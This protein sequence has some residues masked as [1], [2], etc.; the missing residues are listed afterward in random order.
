MA[1]TKKST[2]QRSTK[3]QQKTKQTV[4][5]PVDDVSKAHDETLDGTSQEAHSSHKKQPSKKHLM[6]TSIIS[7]SPARVRRF[8]DKLTLNAKLD[9]LADPLKEQ[10]KK[11]TSAEKMLKEKTTVEKDGKERSATEQ[12]LKKAKKTV[13][14]FKS[15]IPELDE[16]LKAISKERVRFS[17]KASIVLAIICD[18]LVEQ[19]AEH[20]INNVINNNKKIIHVSHLFDEEF[21]RLPL[22]PLVGSLPLL[23]K[24]KKEM[25]DKQKQS[26]FEALIRAELIK[27]EKK[28]KAEYKVHKKKEQPESEQQHEPKQQQEHHHQKSHN[29]HPKSEFSIYVEQKCRKLIKSNTEYSTLRMSTEFKDFLAHLVSEFLYRMSVLMLLT[30]QNMKNKTINDVVIFKSL[31]YVLFDNKKFEDSAEFIK[32]KDEKT[33]KE[34]KKKAEESKKDFDE[35]DV[36][37]VYKVDREFYFDCTIESLEHTVWEK[38]QKY[39]EVLGTHYEE[40]EASVSSE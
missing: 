36:P 20:S 12:E 24:T 1:T 33:M 26:E 16:K 38:L 6:K 11:Y 34:L 31:K 7:T 14:K 35:S 8:I 4:N 15:K 5:L 32:V 3:L 25:A 17:N 28:F 10:V 19:L 29:A 9:E 21:E 40:D 13:E 18:E 37:E 22:Y 2:K 23:V 27:A 39:E 30:A